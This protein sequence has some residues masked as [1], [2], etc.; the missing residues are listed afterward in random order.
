LEESDTFLNATDF[1][2]MYL[3]K[4]P[5]IKEGGITEIGSRVK[6]RF[7]WGMQVTI[8]NLKECTD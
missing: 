7:S 3:N 2:I 6:D 5:F 1:A 4:M 8:N